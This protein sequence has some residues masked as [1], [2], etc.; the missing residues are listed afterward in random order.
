MR[1]TDGK[2][3]DL[4]LG[5]RLTFF[6][7]VGLI[8]GGNGLLIWQFHIGRLQAERVS[9]VSAQMAAVLRLQGDLLA[10][11]QRLGELAQAKDAPALQR[12]TSA[13][14]DSLIN[15]VRQTKSAFTPSP[16]G[17]RSD[18]Q[19]LPTLDSIE[20]GLPTQL[21]SIAGLA[22]AGDWDA[23]SFRITERLNPFQ[24][25][26]SA[27]V[28]IVDQN[29]AEE[30]SRSHSNLESV[31]NRI[32]ILVPAT[33]IYTFL[34]A[35]LFSWTIARKV[36][37]VRVEERVKERTRI[38]RELHDTLL[39]S[40]YGTLMVFQMVT[41]L[42]PGRPEEA[43]VKLESAIDQ[44]EEA[45]NEGRDAVQDL[46]S[47][48]LY[49][50]DIVEA[51]RTMG[52]ALAAEGTGSA[53]VVFRVQVEGTPRNLDPVLGGQVYRIAGEGL[54]NAFRHAQAR[55]IEV[56][57]HYS[58]R[59]LRLKIKDDGKGMDPEILSGRGRS[60]HYGLHGMRERAKMVGGKLTV[61]S[62][63]NSGTEIE[64]TIP[65]TLAYAATTRRFWWREMFLGKGPDHRRIDQGEPGPG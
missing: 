43:R 39:Q 46:R 6:L 10:F 4:Y 40:F 62:E 64:L 38:A 59:Q 56:E 19:L 16:V 37:H 9:R 27:L 7:L 58:D 54:R 21:S 18:P 25:E 11:H 61:S 50:V 24:N 48:A 2:N 42:L 20:I 29:F 31:Q 28:K 17:T 26:A 41:K 13:L 23:V 1:P 34:I 47:S 52:E 30:L 51:T 35:T 36:L 3:L 22:S 55:R 15:Q 53:S 5:A 8:V 33:A 63:L 32:L 60:G 45:I 49:S 65:A 57:I 14:R 12:E 44:A